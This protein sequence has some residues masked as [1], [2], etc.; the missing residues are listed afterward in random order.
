MHHHSLRASLFRRGHDV[1]TKSMVLS[2]PSVSQDFQSDSHRTG[3]AF[4]ISILSSFRFDSPMQ[5]MIVAMVGFALHTCETLPLHNM[6]ADIAFRLGWF[7][8]R[9]QSG[10]AA[11]MPYG[12]HGFASHAATEGDHA[13]CRRDDGFLLVDE[14]VD[15]PMPWKPL[16]FRRVILANY[17]R[18]VQRPSHQ[19]YAGF[20]RVA[21]IRFRICRFSR[22]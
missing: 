11:S 2:P 20:G 7:E 8:R 10:K 17:L 1:W 15:A 5:A 13:V 12:D 14:Q 21:R 16:L 6:C 9:G 3:F 22:P 4:R 19:G 18:A